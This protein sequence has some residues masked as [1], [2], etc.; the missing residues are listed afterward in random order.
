MILGNIY[1]ERETAPDT[2]EGNFGS[3]DTLKNEPG[4]AGL[5]LNAE[6]FC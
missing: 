1:S 2:L 4:L 3:S 5:D 6:L